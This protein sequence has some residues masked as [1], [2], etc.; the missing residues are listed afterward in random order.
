MRS[1]DIKRRMGLGR[2]RHIKMSLLNISQLKEYFFIFCV[3]AA[4]VLI[5]GVIW[6]FVRPG[7]RVRVD[8]ETVA[9][10]RV[11]HR[12]IGMLRV[13]AAR[14]GISFPE[15]FAV[16][17]AENDFFPEKHAVYDLSILE[18]SYVSDFN[19]LIRRYN[20]RSLAPY[21]AMFE[22]L[23]NEI[24]VFP[25]PTGWYEDN[26]S[27]MFG[28]SWGVEH[29]FQGNRMHMGT[30]IID[31]EN[32]RGR[33]PIVS[34]TRGVVREAGWDNQLGY[35]VEIITEN[36]TS[37]LYAHL[38]SLAPGLIGGQVIAAGEPLGQMG[39]TGGRGGR[40][41]PVHLHLAISPDVSFTRGNFW[42][43]PYPLL[44]YIENPTGL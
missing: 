41:F 29:N 39:N 14:N 44:R 9:A 15:L 23:F 32:I 18:G 22:N 4:I 27:V 12:A 7:V 37:Y 11:P 3:M 34:M 30:A 21:I 16:F 17:N 42:I 35:F 13:Y 33:V 1:R 10:F 5:M 43:N 2:K 6:S 20:S 36:G 25:I 8:A 19:K 24:E 28:D 38:D 40:S 26:S 31:R